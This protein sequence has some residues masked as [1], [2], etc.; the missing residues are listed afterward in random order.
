MEDAGWGVV[1]EILNGAAAVGEEG[2][3]GAGWGVEGGADA[4][5]GG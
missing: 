5:M 4:E 1:V 3:D 2:E